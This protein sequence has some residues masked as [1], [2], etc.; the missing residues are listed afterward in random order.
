M[1]LVLTSVGALHPDTWV[2]IV[3]CKPPDKVT[4]RAGFSLLLQSTAMEAAQLASKKGIAWEHSRKGCDII[5]G[6]CS[7][8]ETNR[9]TRWW[10]QT[11]FIFTPFG[12]D[13]HFD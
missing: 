6:K 11:F 13:S 3:D 5:T 9:Y 7:L 12:E 4:G 8:G 1:K 10:F 2:R